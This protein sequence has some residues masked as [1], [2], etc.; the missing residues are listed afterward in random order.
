[1]IRILLFLA[2]LLSSTVLAEHSVKGVD[3][4][5]LS[6][7]DL[8]ASEKFFKEYGNFEVFRRDKQYPAAFL[9]NGSV[10]ITL[11]QVSDPKNAVQFNRKENVGLHHIAFGVPSSDDLDIIYQ[12]LQKDK[13]VRIEFAPEL[14]GS[15]PAKHMMVYEPSGNRVEFIYRPTSK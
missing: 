10:I 4:V 7:T 6:V 12:K 14:L 3:H 9:N 13:K 1:M 11:W 8:K 15:G 2:I 5:G